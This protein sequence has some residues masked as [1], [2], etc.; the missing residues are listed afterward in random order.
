[1]KS[2]A[3]TLLEQFRLMESAP[4]DKYVKALKKYGFIEPKVAIYTSNPFLQFVQDSVAK[5]KK[6]LGVVFVTRQRSYFGS[7]P[8]IMVTNWLHMFE[9]PDDTKQ[10]SGTVLSNLIMSLEDL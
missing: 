4:L 5:K 8:V 3:R 10:I 2:K 9:T 1:M 7:K 6:D